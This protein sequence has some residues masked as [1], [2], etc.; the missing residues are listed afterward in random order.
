MNLKHRRFIEN[1]TNTANNQTYGN[2][3][4]SALLAGYKPRSARSQG[5]EL[6]TKPDIKAEIERIEADRKERST[7]TKEKYIEMLFSEAGKCKN[8]GIRARYIEMLGKA[9]GFLSENLGSAQPIALFNFVKEA[10]STAQP[11]QVI[12]VKQDTEQRS[13]HNTNYMSV[14]DD[15]VSSGEQKTYDNTPIDHTENENTPDHNG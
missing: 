5:S 15:V 10:I 2:S 12:D 4:Q 3:T 13:L 8:E 11:T 9:H 1:Y 14:D 7:L 6:L